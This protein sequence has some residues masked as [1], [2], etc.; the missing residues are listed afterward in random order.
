MAE[1]TAAGDTVTYSML[2][3]PREAGRLPEYRHSSWSK[4]FSGTLLFFSPQFR[5]SEL[6][7]ITTFSTRTLHA[8]TTITASVYSDPSTK[9][10]ALPIEQSNHPT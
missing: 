10:K 9:E 6:I 1:A 7:L 3:A 4:H 5:E 8:D 2:M